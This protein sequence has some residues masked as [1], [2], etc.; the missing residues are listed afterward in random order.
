MENKEITFLKGYVEYSVK[1]R[2]LQVDALWEKAKDLKP[3]DERELLYLLAIESFFMQQET[4]YK[5]LSAIKK[6]SSGKSEFISVLLSTTFNPVQDTLTISSI[7]DLNIIY[8]KDITEEQK[9]LID[10]RMEGIIKACKDLSKPNKILTSIYYALKHGFLI[11]KNSDGVFGLYR[12]E[13]E[14]QL[15]EYF[16]SLEIKAEK[17]SLSSGDFS[18]LIDLNKRIET[19]IQDLIALRLLQLGVTEI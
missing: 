1:A 7:K 3:C 15:S 16:D 14:E 19:A 10:R 18:Y 2:T 17:D 6:A 9:E 4:L 8:P 5:F 11:Y 12:Q 13:K